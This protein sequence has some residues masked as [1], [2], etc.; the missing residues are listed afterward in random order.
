VFERRA[1]HHSIGF[2]IDN[3]SVLDAFPERSVRSVEVQC[4]KLLLQAQRCVQ[5]EL[6]LIQHDGKDIWNQ[7]CP[8]D[9][10]IAQ[11]RAARP[12]AQD[13]AVA[14]LEAGARP[15]ALIQEGRL[16]ACG[17]ETTR[18]SAGPA[19]LAPAH[20]AAH[21]L[22]IRTGVAVRRA[23]LITPPQPRRID[24]VASTTHRQKVDRLAVCSSGLLNGSTPGRAE[25]RKL[26]RHPVV[27]PE[28]FP[29]LNHLP[30]DQAKA[31][32]LKTALGRLPHG[33]GH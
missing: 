2:I 6:E 4:W 7:V 33:R 21:V 30:T 5:W 22:T 31:Q 3:R 32:E 17:A 14:E 8:L 18:R 16:L 27:S 29:Y 19:D 23:A 9:L 20:P 10:G 24:G 12:D 15:I 26:D 28:P 25:N 1:G 13:L 11:V